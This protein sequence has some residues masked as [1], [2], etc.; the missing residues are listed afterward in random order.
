MFCNLW[1]PNSN[2]AGKNIFRGNSLET[3][4]AGKNIFRGNS[5]ETL[6]FERSKKKLSC[7][8]DLQILSLKGFKNVNPP[9]TKRLSREIW[10]MLLSTH[11]YD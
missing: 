10:E 2:I 11:I 7:D 1:K 4:I 8:N 6:F 5:L 9:K 3:Y